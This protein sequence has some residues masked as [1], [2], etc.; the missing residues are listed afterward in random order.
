MFAFMLVMLFTNFYMFCRAKPEKTE[1]M[2]V[3]HIMMGYYHAKLLN[4]LRNT[5]SRTFSE[6][7]TSSRTHS[8]E[9][10]A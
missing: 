2:H 4:E 9:I 3:Y 8:S 7:N 6:G 5:S 1:D 10:V